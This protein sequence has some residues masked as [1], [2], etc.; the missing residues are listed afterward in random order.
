M[1]T[2]YAA[3]IT[4]TLTPTLTRALPPQELAAAR[5]AEA[6][7][8]QAEM[9]TANE[10]LTDRAEQVTTKGRVIHPGLG[11]ARLSTRSSECEFS[12]DRDFDVCPIRR[13]LVIIFRLHSRDAPQPVFRSLASHISKIRQRVNPLLQPLLPLPLCRSRH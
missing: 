7:S 2:D 10:A 1:D 3:A 11:L 6:S 13:S 8:H 9:A 12:A 4:V 5:A